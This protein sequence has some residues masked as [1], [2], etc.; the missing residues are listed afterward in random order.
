MRGR[1][2]MTTDSSFLGHSKAR[3]PMRI[4]EMNSYQILS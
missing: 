3:K 1:S 2:R 4:E